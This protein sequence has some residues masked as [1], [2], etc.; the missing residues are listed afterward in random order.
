MVP[1]HIARLNLDS[2]DRAPCG[3]AVLKAMPAPS[4]LALRPPF[5]PAAPLCDRW[6]SVA[7]I[8]SRFP[9]ARAR[10]RALLDIALLRPLPLAAPQGRKRLAQGE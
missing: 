1:P 3:L 7:G 5:G 9:H 8:W 6:E 10:N 4:A 2:E